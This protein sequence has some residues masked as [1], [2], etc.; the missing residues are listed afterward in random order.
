MA[1]EELRDAQWARL[2]APMQR[3]VAKVVYFLPACPWGRQGGK[4]ALDGE[5]GARGDTGGC[6]VEY[7]EVGVYR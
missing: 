2:T 6:L 5:C 3:W 7:Q 4:G 1:G